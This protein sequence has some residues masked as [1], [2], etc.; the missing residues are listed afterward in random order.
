M[1]P[2]F[3]LTDLDI[4]LY[5]EGTLYRS[6]EKMGAHITEIEGRTG[7]HF[8]VW[9]PNAKQVSVIGDWNEW[10]KAQHPMSRNG[11]SG[12]WTCFIPD[13]PTEAHYKYFVQSNYKNYQIDKADPYAFSAEVAPQTASRIWDLSVY[14]WQDQEWMSHRHKHH[15][16]DAPISI[17]E[18]HLGSWRRVKEENNRWL[19]YREVAPLLVDYIRE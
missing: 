8:A 16:L 5:C 7:T 17:Y 18:V 13:V 4:Q 2:M 12:I 9:A 11:N 3:F 6:Y 10:D 1:E 14:S 15:A 19:T